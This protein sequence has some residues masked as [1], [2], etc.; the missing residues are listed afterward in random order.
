[1][2]D[3]QHPPL[4]PVEIDLDAPAREREG[5]DPDDPQPCGDYPV[6]ARIE[7]L[8]IATDRPLP[9]A[10]IAELLGLP[11]RSAAN[12]IRAAIDQLNADYEAGGRSFRARRLAG[13]WQILTEPAFGELLGRLSRDRQQSHLTAAAMETLAI[14]AYRQPIMRA[15][16]EAIRGVSSG[17]VLR[18]LLERRLVKIVG[19]AE[20]L[21]RPM[22]YGTTREFLK[23][24]G[25]SSLED[26][27]V[28]EGGEGARERR[29]RRATVEA[30]QTDGAEDAA[31]DAAPGDA[32]PGE[33]ATPCD[34]E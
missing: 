18:G 24:F 31:R 22:L 28:V 34:D 27:P 29:G 19:R 10:R 4:E 1:M 7:A 20:E 11:G 16:I 17:E 30:P 21:G 33:D 6:D 8:L 5:D 23:V 25:L 12:T 32:A 2:T 14:V 3:T 26:L 9:E 15:E 13:G